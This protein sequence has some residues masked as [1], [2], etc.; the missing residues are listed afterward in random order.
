VLQPRTR[1]G[2][3]IVYDSR[4]KTVYLHGGNAGR[5]L[6]SDDGGYTDTGAPPP[7]YRLD[8]LWST[9]LKRF[10]LFWPFLAG[11]LT[12]VRPESQEAIRRG[13]FEIRCQQ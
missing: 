5:V 11:V 13:N 4:N 1:Y 2:H 9:T 10:V 12:L 7:E 8:D 6:E 3:Q